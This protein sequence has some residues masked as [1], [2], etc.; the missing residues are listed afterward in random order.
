[1]GSIQMFMPGIL[2]W[3]RAGSSPFGPF[4]LHQILRS[5]C[6]RLTTFQAPTPRP[7][8]RD[9]WSTHPDGA[10]LTT[11]RIMCNR[12]VLNVCEK[13]TRRESMKNS[14]GFVMR[15]RATRA[16][17]RWFAVRQSIVMRITVRVSCS[18]ERTR[19]QTD[20]VKIERE[21]DKNMHVVLR[22]QKRRAMAF[23]PGAMA[24][25]LRAMPSNLLALASNLRAMASSLVL[26]ASNLEAMA[27]N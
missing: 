22:Q 1:M 15:T 14:A 10:L 24:S 2:T 18:R 7:C 19:T 21:M 17:Q 8:Q 5:K 25:N 3:E 9:T 6:N 23:N 16:Q 13:K 27:F 11:F 20:Q 26:M 12:C 4:L